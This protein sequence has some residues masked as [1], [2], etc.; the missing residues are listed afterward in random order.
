[1]ISVQP[2]VPFSDFSIFRAD[3]EDELTVQFRSISVGL[4]GL[5]LNPLGASSGRMKFVLLVAIPPGVVTV[6]GPDDDVNGTV[7][8]I[9][10]SNFTVKL[11]TGVPLNAT[12]VAP[13]K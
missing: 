1:M 8:V 10:L 5:A 2:V 4:T 11:L 12:A 9:M 3:S 6:I 7:V 13:L